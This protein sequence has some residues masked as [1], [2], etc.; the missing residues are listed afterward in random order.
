MRHA[1]FAVVLGL[2]VVKLPLLHE[3]KA[4]PDT[5][6]AVRDSDSPDPA[7][8][9]MPVPLP[10]LVALMLPEVVGDPVHVPLLYRLHVT[11]ADDGPD[12]LT[13]TFPSVNEVVAVPET[14]PVAVTEYVAANDVGST[15]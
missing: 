5:V 9:G 10:E 14:A 11:P 15:N 2:P 8:L 6:P 12:A 13:L 4:K 1:G 7:P 3:E